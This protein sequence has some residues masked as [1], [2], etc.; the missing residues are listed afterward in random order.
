MEGHG[1]YMLCLGYNANTV[2]RRM[3]ALLWHFS[4]WPNSNIEHALYAEE[5]RIGNFSLPSELLALSRI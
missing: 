4:Q 5:F 1:R 3:S 2:E